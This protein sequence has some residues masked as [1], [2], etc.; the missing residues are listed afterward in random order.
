MAPA[1]DK[2]KLKALPTVWWAYRHVATNL[3]F[4]LRSGTVFVGSGVLWL[5]SMYFLEV[6][7][8]TPLPDALNWLFTSALVMVGAHFVVAWHRFVLLGDRGP[9]G[10][11]FG[12]AEL[13]YGAAVLAIF[14]AFQLIGAFFKLIA[15]EDVM[16]WMAV[17]L[18]LGTLAVPVVGSV[19]FLVAIL[20]TLFVLPLLP[21]IAVGDRAMTM[22]TAW[23]QY[24]GNKWRLMAIMVVASGIAFAISQGATHLIW[25]VTEGVF[26]S[27]PIDLDRL[28]PAGLKHIVWPLTFM[29]W[30]IP[31]IA[32]VL[33]TAAAMAGT[34]SIVYAGI[35]RRAIISEP[36]YAPA[37][38]LRER[39]AT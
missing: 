25:A 23:R 24:G 2:S 29:V 36:G 9:K 31:E 26:S 1:D 35:A 32:V 27:L 39:L 12:R 11:R 3:G 13:L 18:G 6:L 28:E 38:V 33:F 8:G 21:A 19:V 34:L 22:R 17:H 37:S 16:E 4:M 7:L 5:L 10:I 20:A 30:L 14:G 15:H